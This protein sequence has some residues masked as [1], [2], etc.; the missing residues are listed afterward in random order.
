M[1]HLQYL[2]YE[3]K[4]RTKFYREE[5]TRKR[6]R[7][8]FISY[9]KW[10]ISLKTKIHFEKGNEKNK[11]RIL[12]LINKTN[13][14]NLSTRRISEN[15]LDKLIKDKNCYL[16]SCKVRDR[17]GDMGLVGV[18]SF[19]LTLNNIEVI[20][21]ILSCRAFGRS[22]EKSML[23]KIIQILKKKENK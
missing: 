2:T 15:E 5:K 13:Q 12:Q 22:I 9:D 11:K 6:N 20:D 17:F 14:M 8:K 16:F 4:N 21:F 3:D 1:L 10:L 18:V 19:R 7:E 23:I